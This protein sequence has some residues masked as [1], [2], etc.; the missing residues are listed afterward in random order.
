MTLAFSNTSPYWKSRLRALGF[1][2][3]YSTEWKLGPI[4]EAGFG[5]MGDHLENDAGHIRNET[6]FISLVTT[7]AGGVLWTVAEDVVDEHLIRHL[8][9]RGRN[10]FL[11]VMYQFVNPAR[12]T[13][14][15]LR[16]RP[17]WYRDSRTVKAISF[18]SDPEPDAHLASLQPVPS[19]A[20]SH[21]PNPKSGDGSPYRSSYLPNDHP[22]D[23]EDLPARF[24]DGAGYASSCSDGANP[25]PHP[26][27]P[28]R[29]AGY[30]TRPTP[31]KSATPGGTYEL[32]AWWGLSLF[33]GPVLGY[34]KDVKYMPIDVRVSYR[35]L[36]DNHWALP[37]SPEI[38]ALAMFDW[39]PPDGAAPPQP[40]PESLRERPQPGRTAAG[41]A[42]PPPRPA[43]PQPKRR[44]PL[45]RQP[46][47][48]TPGLT[49]HVHHRPRR[50]HQHLPQGSPGPPQ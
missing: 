29:A 1:T 45:L 16:F 22:R 13:A 32:G 47:P 49:R 46:G 28:A 36:L 31:L 15:L 17:P 11:L 6:G 48:F 38:T 3:V 4:G 14:N 7:P 5:H 50:R 12:G 18:W 27:A 37:Y 10:P 34:S 21:C 42:A 39:P 2:T 41:P 26:A 23:S 33:S 20:A 9:D 35:L 24:S 40:A 8:E 44:L 25:D 30:V 19:P 43:P